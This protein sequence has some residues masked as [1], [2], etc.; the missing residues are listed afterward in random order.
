VSEASV[1]NRWK[2]FKVI[3]AQLTGA[4]LHMSVGQGPPIEA[5][6]LSESLASLLFVNLMAVLD[7]AI[8]LQMGPEDY[9]ACGTLQNRPRYEG[10]EPRTEIGRDPRAELQGACVAIEQ[11][12]AAWGL[13]NVGRMY[14]VRETIGYCRVYSYGAEEM[15]H[16]PW[17]IEPPKDDDILATFI[18]VLDGDRIISS[19]VQ[20]LPEALAADVDPVAARVATYARALSNRHY[21]EHRFTSLATY[22]THAGGVEQRA[23]DDARERVKAIEGELSVLDGLKADASEEAGRRLEDLRMMFNAHLGIV[24]EAAEALE[25]LPIIAMPTGKAA[26]QV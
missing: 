20:R 24:K 19:V 23:I 9:R 6:G 26:D 22:A 8:A 11:Q 4:K 2:E 7:E 21:D 14:T 5:L 10:D 18:D 3:Y 15:L 13:A 1:Q 25:T 12:L 17:A 16:T